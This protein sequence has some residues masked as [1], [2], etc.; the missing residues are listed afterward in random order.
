MESTPL[1]G[2]RIN[3]TF[4]V[5]PMNE[6][7]AV[8]PENSGSGTRLRRVQAEMPSGRF[9]PEDFCVEWQIEPGLPSGARKPLSNKCISR[10]K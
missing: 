7:N 5:S 8:A 1:P 9:T 2:P 4:G 10:W 6:I 3:L